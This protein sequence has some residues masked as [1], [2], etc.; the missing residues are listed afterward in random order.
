MAILS[1]PGACPVSACSTIVFSD[2]LFPS[3]NRRASEKKSDNS[4]LRIVERR[5]VDGFFSVSVCI[6]GC[7]TCAFL[8][9]A[10][11]FCFSST[12]LPQ[13]DFLCC[14]SQ[15]FYLADFLFFY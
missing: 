10:R 8:I 7:E 14:Q 4:P 12:L 5:G 11:I 9:N 1:F 2:A 6:P 13:K 15:N 3:T